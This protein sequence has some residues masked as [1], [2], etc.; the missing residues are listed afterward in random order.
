MKGNELRDSQ[1][2]PV[3]P[4]DPQMIRKAG[5]NVIDRLHLQLGLPLEAAIEVLQMVGVVPY[6]AADARVDPSTGQT[7]YAPTVESKAKAAARKREWR[8]GRQEE[9][10]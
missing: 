8:L 2:P 3:I 10:S 1:L 6:E 7:I 4:L 9:A 5:V